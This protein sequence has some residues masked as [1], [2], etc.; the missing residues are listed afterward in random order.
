[1]NAR[2]SFPLLCPL[3]FQSLDAMESHCSCPQ[4]RHED[5]LWEKKK[6]KFSHAKKGIFF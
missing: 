2:S 4:G 1:M 5:F 6:I 3:Q